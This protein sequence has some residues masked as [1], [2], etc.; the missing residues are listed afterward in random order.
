MASI[1]LTFAF[2][3]FASLGM[4]WWGV[5]GGIPIVIHLLHKRKYRETTWAAMR[6][7]L[8]AAKKNARRI[9]IEQLILLMVRVLILLLLVCALAQPYMKSFGT[10]FQADVPTHRIIVVDTSFS[11]AY[12][13]AEFSRLDRAKEAAKRIVSASHQ[14][15]A[16]N[17]VRIGTMPP[18]VIVQKPAF[19]KGEVLEEIENLEQSHESSD[20]IATLQ[21][22]AQLLNEAPEIEQ[23]E[24]IV[25]SDFQRVS[26][27]AASGER[28]AKVRALLQQMANK[29]SVS[30]LDVGQSAAP[31]LA[32]TRFTAAEPF[33]TIG[34]PVALEAG[35]T[36]LGSALVSRT[37]VE[38][39]VNGRLAQTQ[40]VELPPGQEVPV[41]FSYSFS[42]PGEHRLEVRISGDGLA[43][44]NRRFLSLP[45]KEEL[46]VLLVNGEPSGRPSDNATFYVETALRPRTKNNPW[47][48]VT[49]PTV[50]RETE[51]VTAD[52]SQYDCILLCNIGL[53]E[54]REA[55][56]LKTYV[57]GG[58][59]LV[60]CLGDNVQP[61][62]YNQVLYAEGQGVLPVKLKPAVGDADNPDPD[63]LFRFDS[64]DL[65]HPIVNQY[66]G[67]PGTGLE[68]TFAFRYFP[69]EIAANSN[70][71]EVLKFNTTDPA[72]LEAP[73][74]Q[75][76]VILFTTSVD[77]RW[78]AWPLQ[79]QTSF[80]PILHETVRFA[81]A[82]RW[83]DRQKDVGEP[84]SRF[85]K[86]FNVSVKMTRPDNETDA[87]R[88]S[89]T[90]HF[91]QIHYEATNQSGIYELA[92]GPPVNLTEWYAVNVDARESALD[93]VGEEELE[94][95]L[96]P[97]VA[98]EYLTQWQDGP[99]RSDS[100]LAE[101]GGLTRWL[102]LAVLCLVLVESLMAW[103]FQYGL[104]LLIAIAGLVMLG[105]FY[106]QNAALTIAVVL[107]LV[108]VMGLFAIRW[109]NGRARHASPLKG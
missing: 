63:N 29:A 57:E 4:L 102:L 100:S 96:F 10:F 61:G 55:E 33:I 16:L 91:A 21:D 9:R 81:V 26:W 65:K 109:R 1:P 64:L 90:K 70:V 38:L 49:R 88:A 35:I 94:N 28:R 20:L 13:P 93:Y 82:G 8:A 27:A 56:L 39:F 3:G 15:D 7:L 72:I 99:R 51:L 50:I 89:E 79:P 98:I 66:E 44:D 95:D 48:G 14:G 25:I 32:V 75:G 37:L 47:D 59:G 67:N 87:L 76:R 68:S 104:A 40:Q 58:G 22:V 69:V 52:L 17:L 23:K 73:L 30:F 11:M 53:F 106:T 5:L 97:G 31:N 105:Q 45:V 18:R 42:L 86:A 108:F 103:R 77:N 78:G 83:S 80:L 71:T 36:N 101:R 34:R 46:N 84:I 60:I 2:D 54:P 41:A 74:G 107:G 24:I 92:I 85:I 6:F 19:Q 62:N 12:Q 43:I